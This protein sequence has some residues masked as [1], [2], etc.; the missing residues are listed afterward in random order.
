M[1]VSEHVENA[2]VHS[3]DATLVTPPQDLNTETLI[4]IQTICRAIAMSLEVSGPF[5]M[6]LIAKVS[7]CYRSIINEPYNLIVWQDNELKVIECNLRVSRSFPFV[8]KTL[9]HDFI[10]MATR[11]I[12]GERVDPVD[13][14][15]GT[16]KVGVKVPQ[17]SFSRLAGKD[18]CCMQFVQL[19]HFHETPQER[20]WCSEWK[21]LQREKLPVSEKIVTK[22]IWKLWWARAFASPKEAFFFLL[23][24][25]K[26]ILFTPHNFCKKI[27]DCSH[28]YSTK[29]RCF[30]ACAP[31]PN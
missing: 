9:D 1:A 11:V 31:W 12:V 19:T 3:G 14:L 6:Q 8:S 27:A 28:Y 20:M 7:S 26:Y 25:T 21:W 30:P 2:G 10:A 15:R 13:V 22:L 24:A 17:F 23:E 16:D 5:N 18:D 29:T 4:K